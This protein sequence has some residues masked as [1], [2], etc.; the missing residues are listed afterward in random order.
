MKVCAS[1]DLDPAVGLPM[2]V[3]LVPLRFKAYQPHFRLTNHS[4]HFRLD[5]TSVGARVVALA[6]C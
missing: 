1:I 5:L 6:P 2:L 4:N 3:R